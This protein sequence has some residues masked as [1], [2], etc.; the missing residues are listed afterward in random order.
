ME[1]ESNSI[2]HDHRKHYT[3]STSWLELLVRSIPAS[4]AIKINDSCQKFSLI[5]SSRTMVAMCRYSLR[6][7]QG[8]MTIYLLLPSSF[9]FDGAKKLGRRSHGYMEC[10]NI[11]ISK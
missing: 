6:T 4:T 1:A 9:D 5:F 8:I 10:M 11:G 2:L 7:N 3:L